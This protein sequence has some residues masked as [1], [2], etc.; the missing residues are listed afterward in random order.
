M[1]ELL[2]SSYRLSI[3][4]SILFIVIG[5]TLFIDPA[6]FVILVSYL[7]GALL[8]TAGINNIISYTKNKEMI[9]SKALLTFGIIL[10]IGGLF[11]IAKPT[12]I[13]KI[14]PTVIGICLIIN[15]IEKLIY[16]KYLKEQNTDSYL[17]SMI[18][19][20]IALVAG[21]FLLFNPLSGTLIVTQI[22]G[23]IIVIYS[24]MDLI[25]KLRF[26][27]GIKSSA[28]PTEENIKIID[29]K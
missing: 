4:Y 15:S 8:V 13:G 14:I 12:F 19:G 3:I 10:L 5:V 25:E 16:L 29:E 11:L 23:V 28:K 2:K 6:G 26:K 17:I 18:S 7:I 22:I 1:A 9:V 20:I 21:I 27:K 24:V